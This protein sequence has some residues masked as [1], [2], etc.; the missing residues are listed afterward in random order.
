MELVNKCDWHTI[1]AGALKQSLLKL[2]A[3]RD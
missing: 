3:T 1:K 2:I